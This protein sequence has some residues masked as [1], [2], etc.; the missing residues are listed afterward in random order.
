MSSVADQTISGKVL[1]ALSNPNY[2]W[3]T[4]GGLEKE[5]ELPKDVLLQVLE[6]MRDDSLV[7]SR[8]RNGNI[9]YTT[10]DHYNKTK[11]DRSLAV[12]DSWFWIGWFIE[13]LLAVIVT[14]LY[15]RS[16]I[17]LPP[18][19]AINVGAFGATHCAEIDLIGPRNWKDKLIKKVHGR[20]RWLRGA[21][22][23]RS[24]ASG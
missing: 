7:T 8:G 11:E 2:V 5:T 23:L 6:G 17:S 15:L 20:L 18:L 21:A 4:L 9:V 14:L 13:A 12:V 24:W 1:E 3:R 10:R 22:F 16:G 19:L